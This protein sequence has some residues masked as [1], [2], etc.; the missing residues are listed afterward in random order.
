MD[1][2]TKKILKILKKNFTFTDKE[3]NLFFNS[4]SKKN[5]HDLNNWDSL[6]TVR[7]F[8]ILEKEFKIKINSENFSKLDN[9]SNIIKYL[10]KK[11]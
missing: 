3:L 9:L 1:N 6:T 11:S 5:I 10:K 8:L 2:V 4:K 7:F